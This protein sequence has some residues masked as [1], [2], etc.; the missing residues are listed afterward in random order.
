MKA[1]WAGALAATLFAGTIFGALA[2]TS[3]PQWRTASSLIGEPKYPADFKHYDHVN[4]QAPKGGT[5]NRVAV[6]TFDTLNPYLVQGVAAAGLSQFGGGLL[7]DTLMA[8][9]V[10]QASTQYPLIAEALQYPDDYSWVKFR[11]NPNAKWHDG[12]PITVEDVIWSFNVLKK[13]SPMY[14]KYFGDVES[15]EKTGEHEV[16]FTFAKAGNRELPQIIGGLVVLPKHW[17]EGKDAQGRQ[18][19]ISRP[20]LEIPL[21]SSAYRIEKVVPGRSITY[22]RVDDY[23]G[24]DLPVNVG[25]NN[26]DRIHYEYYMNEDT[27]WEAF[28]KGG[29]DDYRPEMRIQRWMEGYDFPA[30]QRGD[31]IKKSFPYNAAGRMQAY[32]LN[33]RKPQ[34]QD[35]KVRKALTYAFDFESMN[36]LLFFN[37]YQRINSY[38]AGNELELKGPPTPAEVAILET[39]EDALPAE[40]LTQEFRLPVNDTPQSLR[41]NLLTALKLFAEAG[42]TLKGSKLVNSEGKQFTLEF[43]GDDPTDDRIF[44]PF[45]QNLRKIGIDAKVRIVDTAQYQ[46]RLNDFDFDVINGVIAQSS[47]PGNEQR[48]MWGSKA[49]D[50][51]G[52]RNYAGIRNPAID[53]L[54]ERLIYAKDRDDLVAATHALDRALLWNYYVVPQWYSDHLNVAYWNKFGMPETQPEYAGIDPY[55]WWIDP[56]KEAKLKSGGR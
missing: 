26:F 6:G 51:K 7:Y 24:K 41:K 39:V 14:N 37:Q 38:F 48:D 13:Q 2:D 55:S 46:A 16:K 5:L 21:G 18:R 3:E 10:D 25:R 11:L 54:I 34:L 56:E 9:A 19:D 47:S 49:A 33:T 27:A 12:Q 50:M 31:V 40:A 52:S 36:R 4:P 35:E 32:F 53:K 8:D 1:L 28:K 29:H 43:L 44:S 23:W 45:V 15:A 20:T 17:W 42:W 30:V 22:A